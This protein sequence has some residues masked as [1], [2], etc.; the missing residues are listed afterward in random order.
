MVVSTKPHLVALFRGGY[1]RVSL[2]S[3]SLDD[4][5]DR[6]AECL[7]SCLFTLSLSHTLTLSLSRA[8]SLSLAMTGQQAC[9]ESVSFLDMPSLMRKMPAVSVL[10]GVQTA[11]G[12]S[13]RADGGLASQTY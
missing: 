10:G 13:A 11:T 5:D 4:L 1:A 12:A 9:E 2:S 6:S 8:R 7:S 3:F